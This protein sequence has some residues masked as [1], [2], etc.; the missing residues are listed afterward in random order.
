VD[1]ES[2]E[3]PVEMTV[4]LSTKTFSRVK[5]NEMRFKIP[6]DAQPEKL[7]STDKR[8][9]PLII[10]VPN[11]SQWQMHFQLPAGARVTHLPP[12]FRIDS[13]CISF[14]REVT[15]EKNMVHVQQTLTYLCERISP[16]DYPF[17]RTQ[18]QN[19]RHA[20]DDDVVLTLKPSK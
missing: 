16:E 5:D 18:V 12:V 1:I 20:L 7:F 3:K 13:S 17:Y 8:D 11:R 14:Q 9:Y 6:F 10:G 4:R 2:I 15:Q 19:L